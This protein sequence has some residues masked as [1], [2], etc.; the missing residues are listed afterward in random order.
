MNTEPNLITDLT[1]IFL[2]NYKHKKHKNK[3]KDARI[4]NMKNKNKI[5]IQKKTESKIKSFSKI[6]S[7]LQTKTKKNRS[8]KHK[9]KRG[10]MGPRGAS[11]LT[12]IFAN[13]STYNL[14][15]PTYP[16]VLEIIKTSPNTWSNLGNMGLNG[17]VNCIAEFQDMLYVGG[18]F[19]QTAD[20][21]I[22]NLN[23]IAMYNPVYNTWSALANGGLNGQVNCVSVIGNILYIGGSFSGT[24]DNNSTYFNKLN[25]IAKYILSEN[26][27]EWQW[28]AEYGLNGLVN[29]IAE[30]STGILYIGG[31]FNSVYATTYTMNNIARYIPQTLP[32]PDLWS[33]L[34]VNNSTDNSNGLNGSVNSI[35][36]FENVLYIGG[37]FVWSYNSE[38][39]NNIT[40]FNPAIVPNGFWYPLANEGLDGQVVCITTVTNK[41]YI[42]GFF[43]NTYDTTMT[44]NQIASYD[45]NANNSDGEWYPLA[46][47]GLNNL[48]STLV[49]STNGLLWVGGTFSSTFDTIISNLNLVATYNTNNGTWNA[50]I[51]EGLYNTND[52]AQVNTILIADSDEI[53]IG[54]TIIY[55]TGDSQLAGFNNI[56]SYNQNNPPYILSIM[57]NNN[58]LTTLG[59]YGESVKVFY[60]NNMW[61]I[62]T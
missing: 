41:L 62:M 11:N 14:P 4:T 54:G 12:E 24:A 23:N 21:S 39:S 7:K 40:S 5:I 1:D 43:H 47:N 58:T 19:S 31:N 26:I 42:G 61:S 9:C 35:C 10:P 27:Y 28:L 32:Y 59:L 20:G 37:E 49:V 13:E 36:V 56:V 50:L 46:N 17:P 60:Y 6:S 25:N 51:N 45:P 22:T 38:S 18:S 53:F 30:F 57:S 34:L 29:C 52:E 16:Q 33:P 3:N 2:N 44:L 15:Q 55:K 48:V 8:E